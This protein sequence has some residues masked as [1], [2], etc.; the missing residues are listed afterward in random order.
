MARVK[1]HPWWYQVKSQE[2]LWRVG[3]F[4]LKDF[5]PQI[6]FQ[7]Y[8]IISRK[9]HCFLLL[10]FVTLITNCNTKYQ[11][12]LQTLNVNLSTM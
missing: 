9:L 2:L 5:R 4:F 7:K 10:V 1:L 8:Q 6:W 3:V 11:L 12:M